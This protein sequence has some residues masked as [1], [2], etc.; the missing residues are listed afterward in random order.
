MKKQLALILLLLPFFVLGQKNQNE[1]LAGF[2]SGKYTVFKVEKVSYKKYK[3]V[4]VKKQ[5]PIQIT[6][7]GTEVSNVL[8]K[9]AGI[10]DENFIPDVPGHPA[11]FSFKSYRLT[12]INGLGIYYSWNGK[13]QATTKYVFSK[14]VSLSKK[15]EEL[16]K[17][18]ADY[19]KAVFKNQTSA[20][21]NVKEQKKA[22]AEAERKKNS[23]ENKEVSNI[24]IKLINKPQ[25]V[26]HF[27]EAIKYGVVATLKD[28]S[29]LSTENLGGK[30]P[31]SDFTLKNKGCS[32]TIDEVRVDEDAK[33]LKEDRITIELISKYH[34]SLKAVKHINTTNN[35]SIQVNQ[36]GFWGYNRHK[37]VTVFQGKNGQHA[38][39]GDNLT[40]KVKTVTH[41]QTGVKLNKIDI[42]NTTKQK[43]VARYKL[44]TG[45]K[46]IVNN[47][48]GGGMN[49]FEGSK[50]SPNGGNGGN[51]GAGGNI[52]LIKDPSVTKLNIE[53]NNSGGAAGK[54]GAPKYSHASRGRNGVAGDPG[55]TTKQTKAVQLNF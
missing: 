12:F 20:R 26:A 38:G 42:Y 19:A 36:N 28:G 43:H 55:R 16:N 45:T 21:A 5:W 25:K 53:L 22:V 31:W 24:Q 52:L 51:G 34:P 35:I 15:Y 10:L 41:K 48:G 40:I 44:T 33:S 2:Q 9:R 54:G 3:M 50:S 49:G 6:K 27:S 8:V 30:L 11:Y 23:L 29:K 32:N 4:K 37:H 7:G 17:M 14:S 18:V 47:Q 13:E 1:I 39:R 46:L